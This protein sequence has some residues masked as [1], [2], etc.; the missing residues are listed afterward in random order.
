M[1]TPTSRPGIPDQTEREA[2]NAALF[3]TDTETGFWDQDGHPAPWPDDID[4]W[5]AELTEPGSHD[6]HIA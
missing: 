4:T 5:T 3:A 2:R 6:N 1:I